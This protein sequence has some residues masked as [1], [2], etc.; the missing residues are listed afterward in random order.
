MVAHKSLHLIQNCE[1][2]KRAYYF[3]IFALLGLIACETEPQETTQG[4][5]YLYADSTEIYANGEDAVTFTVKDKEG[6]VLEDASI[7]FADTPEV[8]A[9]LSCEELD[10]CFTLEYYLKNVDFIFKRVGIL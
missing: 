9:V 8:M 1:E 4:T 7:Y 3:L 10:S 6:A 2:M 5:L